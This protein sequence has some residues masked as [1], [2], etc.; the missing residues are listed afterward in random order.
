M[1]TKLKRLLSLGLMTIMVVS[2]LTACKGK[3]GT[4][5][6]AETSG[7][8]SGTSGDVVTLTVYS[9]TANYSGELQ[10]WFA[11]VLLDKFNVKLIIVPETGGIYETRME[12]GDLGDL[13]IW[14]SDDTKYLNAIE[15]GMLYDWKEDNLL[16]EYGPYIAENMT[17]ALEKNTMISAEAAAKAGDEEGAIYG[18][19]HNVAASAED[20][21]SF[22]YTWDL[23]WD[24]YEQLGRPEVKNLDDMVTLF[25]KMKE[26]EPTDDNGNPTY[27]VSLW[28]DWDGDMVMYVKAMATGYYGYDELGIGQYDPT[29]GE[30]HDALE[31]DGPY[32]TM[33]K[34]FNTLYQKDLLDPNSMT[35][36]YDTM[37]EKVQN[38]GTFFS[39]FNYSGSLAYNGTHVDDNKFMGSFLPTEASPIVYG[40]NVYGGNRVWAI[41]ANTAYPELCMEIINYLTTPEGRLTAD[42]GPKGLTWDYDE[43]GKTYFTDLGMQCQNDRT[44][45][46][47]EEWG[48]STFNDGAAQMNN[49]TWSAQATNPESG[50][51]Y[52][53]KF[54]SSTQVGA[55][56]ETETAWREWS[57]A[58]SP[59]EY[60]E[61]NNYVVAP[62]TTFTAGSRADELEVIWEQVTE[63][64]VNYSWN[65][66]YAKTDAEFDK[67][68]S[69][70]KGKAMQY[71]YSQ[72]LDWSLEKAAERNVLEAPLR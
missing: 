21:E 36:T 43:N 19:G 66:I 8:G 37:L 67:V 1:K 38:G 5:D 22:F 23:R 16:E 51:K 30:Y 33:L 4:K 48:G 50:E 9:Q 45:L 28:P 15:Q 31:A 11:K 70:M 32:I 52:D 34:F 17:Y 57:G 14:G 64:I 68:I 29:N 39:I 2:M 13:I 47:P 69:E 56:N 3:V 61:K 63:C 41:G 25:E 55:K 44:T 71:G 54:W 6:G 10:G 42:Y 46:M 26:I 18:F 65:A 27:A 58:S 53:S 62:G 72:C 24:L 49:T 7:D 59:D 60:L 40:M 20:H 35:Q 12:T